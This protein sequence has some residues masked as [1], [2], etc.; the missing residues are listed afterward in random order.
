MNTLSF[1]V[2]IVLAAPA[3]DGPTAFQNGAKAY[4]AGHVEEAIADW[5]Q[6]LAAGFRPALTSYN[7]ACGHARLGHKDA[8]F[9]ML[10]KIASMGAPL[11][12][13]MRN[14][15][16]L[17]SLHD[18]PRWP[19]VLAAVEAAQFPC[20][21]DPK[22]RELDFWIGDW[23]V[24]DARGGKLGESHVELIL[25]DCVVYENWTSSFGSSGKSFNL[26]D[27]GRGRW[28]QTWVDDSGGLH[29]YAGTFTGG[30]MRYEGE[31][32]DR[33]GKVQKLRMSFTPQ[34]DGRVRQLLETS[35]DGQSWATAFDGLYVRRK[36]S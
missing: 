14:D 17:A 12:A 26:W 33:Q 5:E 21:R 24:V 4:A 19:K 11:F 30:A 1:V 34:K 16:D 13:Q 36:K 32:V 31:T 15:A 6:A 2:W 35:T 10:D 28:R 18:D 20:K 25:A 3:V 27:A 7:L 23:D 22:S 9:A 8:A 29:E